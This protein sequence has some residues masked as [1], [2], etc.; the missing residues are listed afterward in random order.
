M[1]G[2]PINALICNVVMEFVIIIYT[3]D[4]Y[5]YFFFLVVCLAILFHILR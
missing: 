3:M 4:Y 5:Y 1:E 2:Y